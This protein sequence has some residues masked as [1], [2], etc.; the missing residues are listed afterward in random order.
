[1]LL[2]VHVT[3]VLF[4]VATVQA[5]TYTLLLKHQDTDNILLR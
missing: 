2:S 3:S 1:M 5:Q 4:L